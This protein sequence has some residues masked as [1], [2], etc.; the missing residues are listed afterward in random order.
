MAALNMMKNDFKNAC[1]KFD[2]PSLESSAA[3]YCLKILK[4]FPKEMHLPRHVCHNGVLNSSQTLSI[5]SQK[6]TVSPENFQTI[7]GR[8]S[9]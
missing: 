7:S 1:A 5:F 2:T 9:R 4:K 6:T 8:S 3:R